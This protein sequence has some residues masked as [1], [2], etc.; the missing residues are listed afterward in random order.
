MLFT[1]LLLFSVSLSVVL[2]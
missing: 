2:Q 1:V